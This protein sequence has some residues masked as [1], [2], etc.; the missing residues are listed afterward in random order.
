[1]AEIAKIL[2]DIATKIKDLEEKIKAVAERMMMLN[3]TFLEETERFNND[4]LLI[5]Q[6]L[7]RM[8]E[9]QQKTEDAIRRII[10]ESENFAV[11]EQ[12][13]ILEKQAKIFSPL[14][15]VNKNEVE[16]MIEKAAEK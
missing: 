5:K 13:E 11:R 8:K 9:K 15:F 1:M 6:E 14:G 16:E 7:Q 2:S 10:K 12:V 4:M 3:S